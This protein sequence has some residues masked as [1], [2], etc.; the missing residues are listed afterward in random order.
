M[1]LEEIDINLIKPYKN[2]PREISQEAVDKV[3]KSIKEFGNNQP[4]VVDQDNIIVVGHTRWK[5]LKA[6]NK[7]T[8]YIIKRDFKKNKAMAYRIM[9]NR[10]GQETK[11]NDELLISELNI[12]KDESFDL[13]LTG[14]D[15]L[16][17]DKY[18]TN[19]KQLL[20]SS[21]INISNKCE[22]IIECDSEEK[23]EEL[24]N[25]LSERGLSCRVLNF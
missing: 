20:D 6:L 15:K 19:N 22:V 1:K 11:W 2:N 13:D 12:L 21:E 14:F 5:A 16:E 17:L 3:K 23:Q 24:Y 4:I 25:E 8:A 10:S 7:K 18:F 9:D